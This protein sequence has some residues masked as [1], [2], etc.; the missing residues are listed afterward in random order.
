MT[1]TR[2]TLLAALVLLLLGACSSGLQPKRQWSAAMQSA[3]LRDVQVESDDG[4]YRG[5]GSGVILHSSEEHGTFIL[6][7]G[8]VACL[9]D[10]IRQKASL[11]E[12]AADV[13]K[14]TQCSGSTVGV[15]VHESSADGRAY[16]KEWMGFQ[17]DVI[18][19]KHVIEKWP[20]AGEKKAMKFETGSLPEISITDLAV[21]H[22]RTGAEPLS[23]VEVAPE[24]TVVSDGWSRVR[25]V[26]Y[27]ENR[28]YQADVVLLNER[29]FGVDGE[30][31]SGSG[32]YDADDRL[33][34]IYTFRSGLT[35]GE[36]S[37]DGKDF[38][39][40]AFYYYVPVEVIRKE[41]AA[42]GLE[43]LLE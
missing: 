2:S 39:I 22:L 5:R 9:T 18:L 36:I 34:G 38:P 23:D 4:K 30:Y 17:G 33:L 40:R 20:F 28:P 6:T 14:V 31:C 42:K 21:V 15:R 43:F 26:S 32:V 41:L 7:C 19:S 29:L 10:D 12:F 11:G 3:P 37:I 16:W 24:G 35:T 25:G 1:R 27:F 13:G 8:H